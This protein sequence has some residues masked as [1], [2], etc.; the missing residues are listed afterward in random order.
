MAVVPKSVAALLIAQ[1]LVN[2]FSVFGMERL[3]P[4]NF[5]VVLAAGILSEFLVSLRCG[6]LA[7][8][9]INRLFHP[10]S[11]INYCLLPLHS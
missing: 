11:S 10:Y 1:F 3:Q 4:I 7:E 9:L 5:D 2:I 6:E 8:N